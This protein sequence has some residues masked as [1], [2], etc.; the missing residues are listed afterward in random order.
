MKFHIDE[1][2]SDAVAQGLRRRGFDVTTT[3]QAGLLGAPD[4]DQLAYC[5]REEKVMVSHD[6]DMLR[7]AATGTP[8]AGIAYCH[9]QKY[10]PGQLIARLLLLSSRISPEEMKNRIEFL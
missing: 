10:K 2:V 4:A 8:H 9:N 7:L 6:A 3:A 5:R 1:H